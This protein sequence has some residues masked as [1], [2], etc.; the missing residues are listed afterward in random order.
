MLLISLEFT[1]SLRVCCILIV[2]LSGSEM[3]STLATLFDGC[4]KASQLVDKN[5]AMWTLVQNACEKRSFVF[6]FMVYISWIDALTIQ[7]L[8]QL[9]K[10]VKLHCY[11]CALLSAS[12][13]HSPSSPPR[14]F[15][16]T[17]FPFCCLISWKGRRK[18]P[19]DRF[20]EVTWVTD[21]LMRW[22]P[23]HAGCFN[24]TFLDFWH[25]TFLVD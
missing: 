1:F 18:S 21:V 24:G 13:I 23:L 25:L 16:P 11:L 7:F 20:S 8:R 17:L 14:F 4:K 15:F 3:K 9:D 22:P 2:Q 12:I 10:P 6:T 5:C 19:F